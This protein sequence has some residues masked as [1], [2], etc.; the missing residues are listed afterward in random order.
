MV[1]EGAPSDDGDLDLDMLAA[2]LHAD[3]GDVRILLKALVTRLSG[4]L[5]TRIQVERA[6][7][8]LRKSEEI[9]R[10]Q[11]RLGDDDLEV[12]VEGGGV[13][14]TIGR[15]SGG[16]RIRNEKVTIDEW[17]RRL[18]TALR[19]EAQ[20]SQATRLALESIVMGDPT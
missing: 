8:F 9:R 12:R 17:L 13:E 4:A 6:G 10:I 16:I 7:G 14:C 19:D 20:S 18:L 2:S 3:S 11:I 5:G 1:I 15:S